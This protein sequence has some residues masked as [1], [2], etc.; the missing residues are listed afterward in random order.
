MSYQLMSSLAALVA[1]TFNP[2]TVNEFTPLTISC[3]NVVPNNV[4]RIQIFNPDGEMV[5][6]LS[7]TVENTTREFG[8]TYS[9]VATSQI[10]PNI[11]ATTTTEIIV[12]CKLAQVMQELHLQLHVT[13]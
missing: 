6:G 11:T 12:R 8:G 4:G 13:T 10:D 7:Y 9:C 1:P 5:G 3:V 2:V